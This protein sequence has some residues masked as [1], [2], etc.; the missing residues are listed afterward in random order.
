MWLSASNSNNAHLIRLGCAYCFY[1]RYFFIIKILLSA[2]CAG[3]KNITKHLKNQLLQTNSR[4]F[5]KCRVLVIY[6]M[7]QSSN[8]DYFWNYFPAFR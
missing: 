8:S 7:A 1:S 4:Q 5:F 2:E 6:K 3:K